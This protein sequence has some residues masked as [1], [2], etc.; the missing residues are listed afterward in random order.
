MK[1]KT[2][3]RLRLTELLE[4]RGMSQADLV[5]AT[6]L[7]ED[8]VSRLCRNL[9]AKLT[10]DELGLVLHALRAT[11]ADL[12]EAYEP[13]VFFGPR[14]N[15]PLKIHLSSRWLPGGGHSLKRGEPLYPLTFSGRDVEAMKLLQ[16]HAQELGIEVRSELH[17]PGFVE[18]PP[19]QELV[20][21]GTH[22]FIGS[23]L[24]S[25]LSEYAL[26]D[27]YRAPAF[28]ESCL[29][30]FPFNFSWGA[31]REVESSFGFK[32]AERNL[33]EGIYSTEKKEIVAT[34]THRSGGAGD[35][36]GLIAVYR[37]E[38][39]AE[40]DVH[41]IRRERCVIVLAGHGR[42]GTL[43][44]ARVLVNPVYRERLYPEM[45]ERPKMFVV[46]TQYFQQRPPEFPTTH[47]VSRL[48]QARI[49]EEA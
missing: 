10:R 47:E 46:Q 35:D 8:R 44:C 30:S 42:H 16:D 34:R 15:G 20:A 39:P 40:E 12:F 37:V 14:W 48:G 11:P 13:T 19:I 43:G 5:R 45:A 22:V 33:A 1:K 21:E 28:D 38:L 27:M 4:R 23:N 6:G 36:C 25:A 17:H 9:W 24:T 7:S 29:E 32:G 2:F 3:V 31:D 18:P 41:G 26:A 49:V